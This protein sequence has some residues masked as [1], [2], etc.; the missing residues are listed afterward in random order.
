MRR[1]LPANTGKDRPSS[2][3]NQ[4]GSSQTARNKGRKNSTHC[5]LQELTILSTGGGNCED[6]SMSWVDSWWKKRH[7]DAVE[8]VT[9]VILILLYV[10]SKFQRW[11]Y[12][13]IIMIILMIMII[14]CYHFYNRYGNE[15]N[16]CKIYNYDDEYHNSNRND[17]TAATVNVGST[18]RITE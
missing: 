4:L 15:D 7:F 11:H 9:G 14:Y 3:S 1:G 5:H 2:P 8:K 13:E 12:K 16:K 10:L 17:T 6:V 18:I